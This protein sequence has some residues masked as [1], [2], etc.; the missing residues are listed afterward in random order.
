MNEYIENEIENGIS[1]LMNDE[2]IPNDCKMRIK[3]F[4]NALGSRTNDI[5]TEIYEEAFRNSVNIHNSRY[6]KLD[7]LAKIISRI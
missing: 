7:I 5:K 6:I 1:E 4:Y 2:R 3:T